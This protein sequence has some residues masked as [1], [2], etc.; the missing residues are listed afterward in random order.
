VVNLW[1]RRYKATRG[2]N[3]ATKSVH[4]HVLSKGT[5]CQSHQMLLGESQDC[6]NFVAVQLASVGITGAP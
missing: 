2:V 4:K 1:E 6:A 5:V 3:P